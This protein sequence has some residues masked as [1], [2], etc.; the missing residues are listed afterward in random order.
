MTTHRLFNSLNFLTIRVDR[1]VGGSGRLLATKIREIALVLAD[2]VGIIRRRDGVEACL[3]LVAE[4]SVET[5]KRWT[6]GL[7]GG[8]HHL[9][10]ALHHRKPSGRDARQILWAPGLEYLDGFAVRRWLCQ[11]WADCTTNIS[12]REFPT[13]TT[14]GATLRTRPKWDFGTASTA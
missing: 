10:P 12:E 2:G 3:L 4:R 11:F 14:I 6:H 5:L 1:Q 9:Q 7:H 8:K 13:G